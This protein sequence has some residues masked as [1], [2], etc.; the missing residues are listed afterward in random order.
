MVSIVHSMKPVLRK[1][2]LTFIVEWEGDA[3]RPLP[4]DDS[5]GSQLHSSLLCDAFAMD[6]DREECIS[7]QAGICGNCLYRRWTSQGFLCAQ[8]IA[9]P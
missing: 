4:M 1:G 2:A 9:Q 3:Y 5:D 8:E 7:D 6:N